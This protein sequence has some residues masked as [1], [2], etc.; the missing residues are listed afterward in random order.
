M[1]TI[2]YFKTTTKPLIVDEP[3][4]AGKGEINKYDQERATITS[5][6]KKGTD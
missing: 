6:I 3:I 5:M 4:S 2:W 1:Q